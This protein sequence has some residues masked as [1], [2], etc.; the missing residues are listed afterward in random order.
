[1]C[2]CIT[3]CIIDLASTLIRAQ[4]LVSCADCAAGS[5]PS[6]RQSAQFKLCHIH[7]S[8]N[9][10][11]HRDAPQRYYTGLPH[12]HIIIARTP[13]I[14][15]YNTVKLISLILFHSSLTAVTTSWKPH[16]IRFLH[17]TGSDTFYIYSCSMWQH[18]GTKVKMSLL[19]FQWHQTIPKCVL[20]GMCR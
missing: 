3:V 5:H 18:P 16:R 8:P 14:V 9:Q 13:T 11:T 12:I 19:H 6:C 10:R 20:P 17:C 2:G 7:C 15:L 4:Y 1:M